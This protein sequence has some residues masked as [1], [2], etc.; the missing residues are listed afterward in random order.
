MKTAFSQRGLIQLWRVGTLSNKPTSPNEQEHPPDAQIA[1]ALAH[2][3]GVIRD[4]K[5]C[6][7]ICCEA[8][9]DRLG[10]LAVACSDGALR[11]L[12]YVGLY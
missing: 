7:S 4:L 2:E 5:W 6:P 8:D 11:I 9:G 1:L 3:Y 12:V 10:V